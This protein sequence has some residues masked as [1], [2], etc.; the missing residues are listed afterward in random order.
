MI[1]CL[2]PVLRTVELGAGICV[3]R[4]AK[5]VC[6]DKVRGISEALQVLSETLDDKFC[7][8]CCCCLRRSVLSAIG[9]VERDNA[10]AAV[11]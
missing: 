7:C 9:I 8:C 11:D 5:P 4:L 10:D 2:V 3:A 1:D 6:E